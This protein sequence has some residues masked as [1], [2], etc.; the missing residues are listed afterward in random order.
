MTNNLIYMKRILF[1]STLLMSLFLAIPALAQEQIESFDV[2]INI[3][4]DATINVQETI[5]YNFGEDLGIE[6]HG[7]YRY[8]PI[9]YER[10]GNNYDLRISQIS[11][12]D[13]NNQP[14]KN[15]VTYPG[16]NVNFKIGDADIH[17]SGI[18][19]YVISYKIRRAIN[20]FD[21]HD[22]LY[23]NVTGDQWDVP[24]ISSSA[25]VIM[26]QKVQLTDL[27][28]TC[29]HGAY[30]ST[31]SCT[32]K[33]Y[34]LESEN[35]L[36][37]NSITFKQNQLNPYEGLTIVFGWPKGIVATPTQKEII[38]DF[39]WDN[40]SMFIFIFIA[41]GC[42]IYWLINGKDP[43]G[44]GTIIAEY[45]APD[46]LSPAEVGTIIDERAQ[47]KDISAEI[48]NLAV[49]GYLKIKREEG[50]GIF[51][52]ASYTLIKLKDSSSLTVDH[53]KKLLNALFATGETEVEMSDLHDT[54]YKKYQELVSDVY[55]ITTTKGYFP[56]R[57]NTARMVFLVI[58]II[59]TIFAYI[60][61]GAMETD[62][63][64]ISTIISVIIVVISSRFMSRKT[65]KGVIAKEQ[66]LGLKEYLTVTEKDRIK[67]HNAPEKNPQIF[68]KLLPYAMVLGVEKQWAG[69]FADIY[70]QPPKWYDTDEDIS[71]FN[72]MYFVS[73]L[74]RFS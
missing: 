36:A 57:P 53:E 4:P 43:K 32:D 73:R 19:T 25:T 20:Y 60:A 48:I 31:E 1:V 51:K 65:K 18:K 64:L 33:T 46:N 30:G 61:S 29:F 3:N 66:I 56:D 10:E 67:F 62:V 72:S 22:E 58:G 14:Y 54:F 9:K 17:V 37:S 44:R 6:R 24:I 68:E 16:D 35:T 63:G 69:Q 34:D 49:K 23:W 45:E 13:E 8:I 74:N 71:H 28:E 50:K 55:G 41:L 11:V 59:I 26:P 15:E 40:V 12:V 2:K 42:F 7:I 39:I 5:R 52:T 70:K 27:Q 21:A 47:S 38:T